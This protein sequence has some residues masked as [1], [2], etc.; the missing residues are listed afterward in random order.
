MRSGVYYIRTTYLSRLNLI[1]N[2]PRWV[3]LQKGK[4]KKKNVFMIIKQKEKSRF[5]CV[6]LYTS[7]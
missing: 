7:V 4:K 6:T 5:E 2:F 1:S 3:Y